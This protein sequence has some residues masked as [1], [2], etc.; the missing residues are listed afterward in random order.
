M[1]RRVTVTSRMSEVVAEERD[2]MD[3]ALGAWAADTHNVAQRK[4]PHDTGALQNSGR[5]ERHEQLDWSVSFGNRQVPYARRRH[6][7]NMLNP[8][9]L[10]YL[11]RAGDQNKHNFVRR[12]M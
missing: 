1:G 8:Q 12:Y 9:T 3:G 5:I 7:E 11:E 2:R 10:R 4:A 6:F